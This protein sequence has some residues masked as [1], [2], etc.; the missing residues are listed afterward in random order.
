MQQG[1]GRAGFTLLA[2]VTFAIGAFGFALTWTAFGL[3]QATFFQMGLGV[4]G[5]ALLAL[6]L[7]AVFAPSKSL[8]PVVAAPAPVAEAPAP[9][10]AREPAPAKHDMDYEFTD[11]QPAAKAAPEALELP[12]AFQEAPAVKADAPVEFKPVS[13]PVEAAI[14]QIFDDVAPEPAPVAAAVPAAPSR[15]PAAWP[16]ARGKSAWTNKVDHQ[17]RVAEQV[18]SA[19]RRH[20]LAEK[21]TRTTPTLRAILDDKPVPVPQPIA[22]APA[23]S[24]ASPAVPEKLADRAPGDMNTDFVAPGMSVGQCGQCRTLLLAPEERPLRLKCPECAKVTLLQ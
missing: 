15:D 8:A 4:A 5:L 24:A 10:P 2:L 3:G 12:K 9:A 17:R 11:Y 1:I 19:R 20:D 18:E 21:Y 7:F 6:F 23:Q 16:G 13:K 14:D 22:Q